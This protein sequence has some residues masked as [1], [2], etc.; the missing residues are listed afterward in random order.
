MKKNKPNIEALKKEW[1]LGKDFAMLNNKEFARFVWWIITSNPRGLMFLFSQVKFG[2][3]AKFAY[4]DAMGDK[5][6]IIL[7]LTNA[8]YYTYPN[9]CDSK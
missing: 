9:C 8:G 1:K 6:A 2:K 5:N 4:Q 3:S 7:T